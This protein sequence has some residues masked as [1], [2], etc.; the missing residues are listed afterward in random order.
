LRLVVRWT[1]LALAVAEHEFDLVTA[2]EVLRVHFLGR[3]GGGDAV[4]LASPRRVACKG[5]QHA[6]L[7]SALAAGLGES[8]GRRGKQQHTGEYC[9]TAFHTDPPCR[10]CFQIISSHA[11][12]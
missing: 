3:D 4:G 5:E 9:E 10:F 6:D 11:S 2:R 12:C 1:R 7:D 8:G